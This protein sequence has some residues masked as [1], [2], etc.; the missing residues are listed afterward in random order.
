M[1]WWALVGL[2]V[3]ALA[4]AHEVNV[5]DHTTSTTSEMETDGLSHIEMNSL[6]LDL[7]GSLTTKMTLRKNKMRFAAKS[8][9]KHPSSP[10]PRRPSKCLQNSVM[11]LVKSRRPLTQRQ[12]A[13]SWAD[14]QRSADLEVADMQRSADLEVA[15]NT[16]RSA[17]LEVADTQR[18]ADLEVADTQRSAEVAKNQRARVS[19]EAADT[20]GGVKG[21]DLQRS[22]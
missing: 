15:E 21:T 17:D 7:G 18:S 10:H 19:A 13:D 9:M 5:P 6:K 16:Q 1:K 3:A 14:T 8:V 20:Q 2:A 22:I 11:L 4:T 12:G